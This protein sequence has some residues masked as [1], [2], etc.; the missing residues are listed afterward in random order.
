M[1]IEY[2]RTLIADKVRNDA[3][4]QSLMA[5][6]VPGKT[7]TVAAGLEAKGQ[8]ANVAA[9]FWGGDRLRLEAVSDALATA[10]DLALA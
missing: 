9:A 10:L 2:H 4:Y 7:R 8:L 1:R 5:V 6:I 3:F